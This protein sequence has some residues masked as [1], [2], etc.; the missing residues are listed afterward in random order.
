MNYKNS[1][2]NYFT[3]VIGYEFLNTIKNNKFSEC[4]SMYDF[5]NYIA[6]DFVNSDEFKN[7]KY[8]GYEMLH[9][10][11]DNKGGIDKLYNDYF[12]HDKES[13]VN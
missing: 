10:F 1:E 8:S 5:A 7:V 13:E 2:V 3:F 6:T 9:I 11:I 4:D 12:N